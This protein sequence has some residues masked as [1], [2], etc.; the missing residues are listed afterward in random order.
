[1]HIT[2]L[3]LSLSLVFAT[4]S[5]CDRTGN[6]TG[7]EYLQR[8]K[9][10]QEQGDIRGSVIDLKNAVQKDPDN[11]QARWL[12]GQ[13]YLRS[14][15]ADSAIKELETAGNLGVSSTALQGDL[16]E[17]L[18]L[19]RDYAKVLSLAHIDSQ[20]S[21]PQRARAMQLRADALFGMGKVSEA[22]ALYVQAIETDPKLAKA[23]VGLGTCAYTEGKPDTAQE[24]VQRAIA[25]DGRNPDHKLI[26]A[27]LARARGDL[28]GAL[29]AYE[30]ALKNE[31]ANIDALSGRVLTLLALNRPKDAEKDIKALRKAYPKHFIVNYLDAAVAARNQQF[32]KSRDLLQEN[33]R[34]A[35]NHL[36]SLFLLGA[37][38][39]QLEHYTLAAQNLNEVLR[40]APGSIPARTLLASLHLKREQPKAAYDVLL[41]VLRGKPDFTQLGLAGEALLQMGR[42]SEANALFREAAKLDSR[43][44]APALAMGRASLQQD[45]VSEAL[46]FLQQA[47][48]FEPTR[49]RAELFMI[50]TLWQQGDRPAA[51]NRL[52]ELEKSHTNVADL[53]LLRGSMLFESGDHAAARAPFE[54]ALGI[55]PKNTRTILAL[56]DVD[57]KAGRHT[58]AQERL[59]KALKAKP[60]DEALLLA[61]A[62]QA[63]QKGQRDEALHLLERAA[64]ASPSALLPQQFLVQAAL[65]AGQLQ[66]AQSIAR[67]YADSQ[68]GSREAKILLANTQFAVRDFD[69][70]IAGYK[71][72]LADTPT[73]P[74]LN[75]QLGLAL[76]ST[77]RIGEARDVLKKA[78]AASGE[79]F[80]PLHALASLEARTGNH[81]RAQDLASKLH[82]KFPQ[83]EAGLSLLGD[84]AFRQQQYAKA[85]DAYQRAMAI[86]AG[87]PLMLKLADTLD[88]L[89]RPTEAESRLADWVNRHPD[90]GNVRQA[91]ADRLSARGNTASAIEHYE[92]LLNKQ[93][94]SVPVL[95]N[96]ATLLTTA[97]PPR[98]LK[99]AQSAHGLAPALPH[100]MDTY[101]WLLVSNNRATEGL[102]YLEKAHRALPMQRS[103][104]F[105]YAAALSKVGN[106]SQAKRELE[107]LLATKASFPERQE[108]VVLLRTL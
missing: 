42:T 81:A 31:P 9:D 49:L 98:A 46:D 27:L 32:E 10:K 26:L 14:K 8:A 105:H 87:S 79:A 44:G 82:T 93:P 106:T 75:L 102:P 70:A 35:P 92:F 48:H 64:K 38:N 107:K 16:A 66:R 89:N 57:R 88:R 40:L 50:R 23:H 53:P 47:S 103:I 100:V 17:A 52:A 6:L 73:D 2:V 24:H 51:M 61:S 29:Q 62:I 95:N 104:N 18:L 91:Y 85:L 72:L 108:A 99:L 84:I 3:A 65:A 78:V 20:A 37:V 97:N 58:Q 55:D 39:M 36:E 69:T 28:N 60:D 94:Q 80:A 83:S 34:S 63:S 74:S 77:D 13:A 86:R 15:L 5:G 54:K 43:S 67:T 56:V 96:L 71:R 30:Q 101:G 11:A 4:L 45:N 76:L 19:K 41:P 12:L 33:L 21:P 25:L 68:P 22:C 90:D 59:A 7:E 1:M